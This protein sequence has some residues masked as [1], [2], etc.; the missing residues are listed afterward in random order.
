LE[1][2]SFYFEIVKTAFLNWSRLK[3]RWRQVVEQIYWMGIESLP[4][5]LI[6]LL[7][8]SL[9][10]V[11]E[12]SF[13]M[14]KV[15]QQDSLVPAF[16]TLLLFRELGPVV[17][18]LLLTSRVG[19]ALGAELGTMRVT[20]QIDALKVLSFDP[21][22]YLVLPRII[23]AVVSCVCLTLLAVTVGIYGA[24]ILASL[25]LSYTPGEFFNTM[26]T[27]ARRHDLIGCLIKS[28]VFG[29]IFPLVASYQG[30]FCERGSEGVGNASTHSVVQ[31]S[32]L[33]IFADFILTYLLYAL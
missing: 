13:H 25:R 19:A 6:S 28:A 23:A 11:L 12:F 7:V 9:M 8:V 26:F 4:V 5:I 27:F 30:F 10:L 15:L 20:D 3:F 32:I 1:A 14:K 33:I 17:T 2:L 16:S 31:S 22:E 24:A 29:A 21:I 18:A